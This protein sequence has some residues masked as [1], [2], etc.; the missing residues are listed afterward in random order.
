MPTLII[1]QSPK[2]ASLA[3]AVCGLRSLSRICMAVEHLLWSACVGCNT[4]QHSHQGSISCPKEKIGLKGRGVL[5]N[6]G[7]RACQ[8]CNASAA[9]HR[10]HYHP[11]LVA[12]HAAARHSC[13]LCFPLCKRQQQRTVLSCTAKG[14]P[15]QPAR[16]SSYVSRQA[17]VPTSSPFR[18]QCCNY[19]AD[20][21]CCHHGL[22]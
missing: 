12:H 10:Q 22:P 8:Q 13:P 2:S 7:D 11:I 6:R 1:L 16:S 3:V 9:P 15:Q 20:G 5:L 4:A 21:C 18:Q 17:A 14:Q 19:S